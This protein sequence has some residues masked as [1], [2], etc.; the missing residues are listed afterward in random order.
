MSVIDEVGYWTEMKL[1]IIRKYSSAYT[2]IMRKQPCIR[3]YAYIDGFAGAG[4]HISRTTGEKIDGSPAL[5]LRLPH[6]FTEYHFIDL[7]G[8]RIV[9]L[10][11]LKADRT[12][13]HVWKGDCN[14]VL[15]NEIFPLFTYESYRR[16]LCLLDP[17]NLNP[18][19][20]VVEKAGEL[21]TI[22]IFL[23]FMIMDANKNVLKNDPSRVDEAQ[24]RRFSAFWGDRSWEGIVYQEEPADLF[25]LKRLKNAATDIIINAYRE[26]LMKVA[27][28]RYVPDPIPMKNSKGVPIYYLF[29]ASQNEKGFEIASNI[30]NKYRDYQAK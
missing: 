11:A 14:D 22:E 28:F 25:G 15:L 8:K 9:H 5:A 4:E 18:S 13:V 17:Y 27:G 29:F 30:L 16:A 20:P 19:W 2:T 1:E 6:S 3:G 23:N 10:R 12:N 7:D 21:R 26:R 24:K